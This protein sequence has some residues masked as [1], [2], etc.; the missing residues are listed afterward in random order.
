MFQNEIFKRKLTEYKDKPSTACSS[1]AVGR[2][3][4]GWGLVNEFAPPPKKK[5]NVMQNINL[6]VFHGSSL[7]LL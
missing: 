6:N 4:E 3:V 2:D 7:S 5:K 1:C